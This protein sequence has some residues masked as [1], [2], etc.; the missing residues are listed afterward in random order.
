MVQ[1]GYMN[2]Q[3]YD[4]VALERQIKAQFGVDTEIESMIARRIPVARNAT[5]SLLLT[6]KKQLFLYVYG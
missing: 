2:D 4:D 6:R 3:L 5:A 1:Y